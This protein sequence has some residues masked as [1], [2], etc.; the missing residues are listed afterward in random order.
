M[1][2]SFAMKQLLEDQKLVKSIGGAADNIDKVLAQ[3]QLDTVTPENAATVGQ[4][5]LAIR[6]IREV[7]SLFTASAD[8][9]KQ[10]NAQNTK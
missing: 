2:I 8:V 9:I 10:L 3:I 1:A 4:E 7:F 5:L 6:N